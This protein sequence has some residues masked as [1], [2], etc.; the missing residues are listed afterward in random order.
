MSYTASSAPVRG[1]LNPSEYELIDS[2][3]H[4]NRVVG[5]MRPSDYAVWGASAVGFP[6]ALVGMERLQSSAG[7]YK[8]ATKIP[9]GAIRFTT[10][11]GLTGGFLW[12]Y[13]RS[14]Q[15]FLGWQENAR[16]VKL[17]RYEIKKSLSQEKLPYHENESLLDDRL[18]DLANR[19]SQNSVTLLAFVPFFNFAHH[20]YH[21][22]NIAKYYETRPG[23]ESWG[24][25]NLK[26]FEEI[27]AKYTKKIE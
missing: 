18:Q 25:D 11:L 19:N 17:D 23:E 5:Y 1:A 21:G 16:E 22:V 3:P 27:K 15:R 14:S 24:F 20:P 2:D 7:P 4:F 13:I 6:L 12:A 26:P 10:F 9:G 8:A